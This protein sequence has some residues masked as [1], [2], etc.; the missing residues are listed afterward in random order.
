[1]NQEIITQRVDIYVSENH[2]DFEEIKRVLIN[3][4]A[5]DGSIICVGL[6]PSFTNISGSCD[7]NVYD[8]FVGTG[9]EFNFHVY[10]NFDVGSDHCLFPFLTDEEKQ[11]IL[12]EEA[13]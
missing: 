7:Q 6:V 9:K 4:L 5:R 12:L 2:P 10:N 3:I 1:M 8:A 11:E 13:S